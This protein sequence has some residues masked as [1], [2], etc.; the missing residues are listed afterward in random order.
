MCGVNGLEWFINCQINNGLLLIKEKNQHW[1][2][3]ERN[4]VAGWSICGKVGP[5]I[6]KPSIYCR[7]SPI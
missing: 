4:S 2:I 3:R 5:T 7:K 1:D 6:V